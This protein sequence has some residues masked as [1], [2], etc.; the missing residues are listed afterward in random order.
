MR[1][2]L[3]QPQVVTV[4]RAGGAHRPPLV[5]LDLV[6]HGSCSRSVIGCGLEPPIRYRHSVQLRAIH[7]PSR[8]SCL[9]SSL[10]QRKGLLKLPRRPLLSSLSAGHAVRRWMQ[11]DRS[12]AC[13]RLLHVRVLRN[14]VVIGGVTWRRRWDSIPMERSRRSAGERFCAVI[15]SVWSSSGRRKT[16]AEHHLTA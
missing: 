10:L 11:S 5:S 13:H 1:T 9:P 3:G 8:M 16:E 15:A 2:G 6:G 4:K 12:K 7:V 14:V